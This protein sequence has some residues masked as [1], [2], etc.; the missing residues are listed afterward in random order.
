MPQWLLRKGFMDGNRS[1]A[2]TQSQVLDTKRTQTHLC[3]DVKSVELF[4]TEEEGHQQSVREFASRW[5]WHWIF[6]G[7]VE[8]EVG[9]RVA[10]STLGQ[11][12]P[13]PLKG[14]LGWAG[15]GM[16]DPDANAAFPY[17]YRDR[18]D[19]NTLEINPKLLHLLNCFFPV[20]SINVVFESLRFYEHYKIVPALRSSWQSI[21]HL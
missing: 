11:L 14:W 15:A 12:A 1:V 16:D 17:L 7:N 18:G 19:G 20:H 10:F 2:D 3:L 6:S 13:R 21:K 9:A 8:V 4:W 5:L